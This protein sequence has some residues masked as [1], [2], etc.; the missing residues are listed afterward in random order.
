MSCELDVGSTVAFVAMVF[1]L[2]GTIC[3]LSL[4]A[5]LRSRP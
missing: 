2:G 4:S 3:G 1:F 5:W